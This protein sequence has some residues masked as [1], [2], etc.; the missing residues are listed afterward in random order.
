MLLLWCVP[1]QHVDVHYAFVILLVSNF[2][3][4]DIGERDLQILLEQELSERGRPGRCEVLDADVWIFEELL[5]S[6]RLSSQCWVN[7]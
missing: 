5:Q 6:V 4:E 2:Y 1:C 7:A 3:V